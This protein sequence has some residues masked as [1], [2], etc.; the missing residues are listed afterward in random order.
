MAD[1]GLLSGFAQ[2][3]KG[4]I[5]GYYD[6]ED[7]DFKR[8]EMA[9]KIA[10]AK[11]DE[12]RKKGDQIIAAGK[13]GYDIEWDETGNVKGLVKNDKLVPSPKP[14]A[15]LTPL[16]EDAMKADIGYK[17]AQTAK[18]YSE[19]SSPENQFKKLPV[20]NQEQIKKIAGASA[21]QKSIY[22]ILEGDM[23][24]LRDPNVSAEQKLVHA[25]SM[26]KTLN[27]KNGSDAV[28][29]EEAKRLAGLLEF[30]IL[31]RIGEPGPLF[32]RADIGEFQSQVE[33]TMNSLQGSIAAN[34]LEVERLYGRGSPEDT[35]DGLLK[36]GQGL[37]KTAGNGTAPRG[38]P[39]PKA[40]ANDPQLAVVQT[41]IDKAKAWL[42]KNPKDPQAG[43]VQK[44]IADLEQQMKASNVG[45]R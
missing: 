42:A 16:E 12:A 23:K 32:G 27:S 9:A 7:R 17:K 41:Q 26:I 33:N 44:Q 21:N 19:S 22:N 18:A 29:A 14:K 10:A 11:S 45:A 8:K 28:G 13:E 35:A 43:A 6:A 20:E 40:P 36:S 2:G 4:A 30:R 38:T 3:I 25:R 39:P 15:P 31:P 5:Q 24:V 34:N 1:E 37:I